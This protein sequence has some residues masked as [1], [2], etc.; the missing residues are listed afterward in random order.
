MTYSILHSILN[1]GKFIMPNNHLLGFIGGTGPE[2]RG[3]ALRFSSVGYPVMIGSRDLSNAKETAEKISTQVQQADARG[4]RNLEVA[5]ESQIAFIVVPYAAQ[6]ETLE[7]L[8]VALAGKIVVSLVVP[9]S[10]S[11]GMVSSLQVPEGSA[12][13]QAQEILTDSKVV[14]AFHNTSASDL[15][16]LDT[17]IESDVLVCS[18]DLPAKETIMGLAEK[19]KGVRAVDCGGLANSRYVE[20]LTALLININ[21]IHN[22]NSSIRIIGI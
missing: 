14:A 4:A 7:Q 17:T 5:F 13:L 1:F 3:L 10:F 11:K 19:I 6:R 2:G 12:T 16:N 22:K 18:D 9:L 21:R 15:L 20:D 8:K